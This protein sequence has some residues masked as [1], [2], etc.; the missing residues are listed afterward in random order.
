LRRSEWVLEV[1]GEDVLWGDPGAH[2][3]AM[4]QIINSSCPQSRTPRILPERLKNLR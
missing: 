1:T 2:K 4:F 3:V